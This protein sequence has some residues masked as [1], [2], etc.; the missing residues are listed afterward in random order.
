VE[1]YT[2]AVPPDAP[3]IT[4]GESLNSGNSIEWTGTADT[5]TIQ[6]SDDSGFSNLLVNTSGIVINSY[7]LYQFIVDNTILGT[8]LS[9]S[10]PV[11][12][13]VYSGRSL[14]FDN[15]TGFEKGFIYGARNSVLAMS[16]Y[17][18]EAPNYYGSAGI[19]LYNGALYCRVKA[20][21]GGLDSLWSSTLIFSTVFAPGQFT[22]NGVANDGSSAG[23]TSDYGSSFTLT[24][25]CE[26]SPVTAGQYILIS[27]TDPAHA[28]ASY[29]TFTFVV[30]AI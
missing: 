1:V 27:T 4:S 23:Q 7:A 8:G 22:I 19:T 3:V 13:G 2:A 26:G 9:Q 6:I 17:I 28:S 5:F 25:I 18:Q 10:E 21:V 12:I 20:V 15:G 11:S 24:S 16:G 14:S 30:T 29:K